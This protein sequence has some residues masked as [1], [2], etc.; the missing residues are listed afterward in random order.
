MSL[1]AAGVSAVGI[2]VGFRKTDVLLI[3]FLGRVTVSA[4]LPHEALGYHQ[5]HPQIFA[6]VAGL[7]RALPNRKQDRIAGI[8][9]AL[10]D[11]WADSAELAQLQSQLEVFVQN[12][13]TSAAAGESI[14]GATT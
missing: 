5:V 4:E 7:I 3:D 12:D 8:G 6:T 11:G 1:N 2:S 13:V 14:F 9:L 10:P